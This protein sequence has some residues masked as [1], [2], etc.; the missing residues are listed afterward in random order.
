M[1]NI[2]NK[3]NNQDINILYHPQ[4]N[5]FDILISQLPFNFFVM[6][7]NGSG[8]SDNISIIHPNDTN[9]Y[10]FN[11]CMTNNIVGHSQDKR[12]ARLGLNSIAFTHSEKPNQ[13]KKED[14]YL[15]NQNTKN[16]DKVFFS[17]YA[18]NTWKFIDK[19]HNINYG[20]PKNIFYIKNDTVR[21]NKLLILNFERRNMDIISDIL[22]KN[23][24]PFDIA[25]NVTKDIG[26]VFNKYSVC[27]EMNEHNIINL[28]CANACGCY[29]ISPNTP[30]LVSDFS[31]L[32]I[33][34]LN[35]IELIIQEIKNIL[36]NPITIDNDITENYDFEVF[37][38]YMSNL[39]T[40]T[41][42]EVCLI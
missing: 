25:T 31:N 36:D 13:I 28:I 19:S 35:S 30:M 14:L 10:Q 22:N 23:N 38:Q 4:N 32:N 8:F 34:L 11:L 40:N 41:N 29:G 1:G 42:Q 39:I 33:K 15:L 16:I 12:F 37:K 21:E 20:I 26:D 27:L 3:Y 9:L 6:S 2:L 24:I 5:L 17:T 18:K 7:E